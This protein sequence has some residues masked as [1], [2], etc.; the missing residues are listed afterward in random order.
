M[1]STVKG[2]LAAEGIDCVAH[3]PL[4]ACR[5]TRSYLLERAG[6][7]DGTVFIF[8]VPY[9]TDS[10]EHPDRN[11]SAYA[12]SRDY[13]AYF[14]ALFERVLPQLRQAF[15]GHTFCGFADHSP[16]DEVGAAVAAGLGSVGRNHLFLTPRHGSYVFLGEIVTDALLPA[17]ACTPPTCEGCNACLK[18]CPVGL[19][20][21]RCLSALTQKK[22]ELSE[23]EQRALLAHGLAWGCDICQE[24]C[25]VNRRA[26]SSGSLYTTVDF[27]KK[28][29][30][31]VLTSDAVEAMTDEEFA[32]RAFAW[33]G[34]AVILRNLKMLEAK[35][36]EKG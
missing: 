20:S 1:Q 10:C 33:R 25:P 35:G 23:D 24:V 19:D 34:R 22:G 21:T 17:A 26:K 12:V 14:S 36:E 15:A 16:I 31:P 8:A 3:L 2:I 29:A 27:F 18:A 4:A 13:H 6:I 28:S 9:Y 5:V 30:T 32:A 11:I 7:A